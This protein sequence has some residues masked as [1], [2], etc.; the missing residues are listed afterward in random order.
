MN[1]PP[2]PLTLSSG[3]ECQ[4][5]ETTDLLHCP[6]AAVTPVSV[7]GHVQ[8]THRINP[9]KCKTRTFL[10]FFCFVNLPKSLLLY[11]FSS[12]L[13]LTSGLCSPKQIMF[14]LIGHLWRWQF[15]SKHF[16]YSP[17]PSAGSL[18]FSRTSIPNWYDSDD[19]PVAGD[20]GI[21]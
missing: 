9:N 14:S 10:C 17:P 15:V 4:L 20:G 2:R 19:S 5:T 12:L 16:H 3:V 13:S 6:R 21:F 8:R 11:F 18:I 7:C 1:H